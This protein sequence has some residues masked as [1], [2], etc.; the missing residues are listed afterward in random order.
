MS[1]IL[2]T[3]EPHMVRC[4]SKDQES[5]SYGVGSD[6]AGMPIRRSITQG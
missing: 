3:C 5:A 6:N 2:T 1:G 4:L